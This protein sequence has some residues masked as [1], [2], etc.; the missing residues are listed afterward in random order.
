MPL[1][2]IDIGNTF[3]HL[4]V[5]D[6]G[7]VLERCDLATPLLAATSDDAL[8]A[9]EAYASRADGVAFAS[10]V[11]VATQGL[12]AILEKLG[13]AGE[14]YNLRYDTVRG[15]P[16]SYPHPAEI[17]Q[18]RL[19]N[20]VAAQELCGLPVVAIS[21]GTA[22]VFDVL[23]HEGYAGGMIAPGLAAL[24]DYLHEKT[25]QLP[26]I[27]PRDL[28][29]TSAIGRSTIEAM[30][31]GVRHGYI[32]MIREMLAATTRELEASGQ[33]RAAV[34]TTG[35]GSNLLPEDWLPGARHIPDLGLIGLEIAFRRSRG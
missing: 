14:A 5:V 31:N 27:D 16:I 7:V 11:P 1:L 33:D 19:A 10:V 34:I 26:Q 17:G 29:T 35:G 2:C 25:A 24:T 4:G 28:A 15:L 21:M 32:G 30:K 8:R 13:R 22:T 20:S 3:A 12:I 18:D 23:T 9:V 6:N